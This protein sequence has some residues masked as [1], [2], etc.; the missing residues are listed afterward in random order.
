M[1]A[2][3]SSP[4]LRLHLL[5]LHAWIYFTTPQVDDA[6]RRSTVITQTLFRLLLGANIW[7]AGDHFICVVLIAGTTA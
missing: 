5:E 4:T 7:S 1:V 6:I 3:S 2:R